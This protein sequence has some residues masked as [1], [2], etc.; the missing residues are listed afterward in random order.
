MARYSSM[1]SDAAASAARVAPPIAMSPCPGSARNRSISS[2]TPPEAR[3]AWPCTA[4]SVVEN[5]TFGSGFQAR[6]TRASSRRAMDPGR[7][8][9]ST[10]S[11]R[12]AVVPAG[13]R[14]PPESR[15]S[16]SERPPRRAPSSRSRRPA[17]R[18]SRQVRRSSNTS[19][20]A[21]EVLLGNGFDCTTAGRRRLIA[22]RGT[23][24]G[25]VTSRD[26]FVERNSLT[27]HLA[28]QRRERPAR[29]NVVATG[30]TS[31]RA[32]ARTPGR[33]A[34]WLVGRWE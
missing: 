5:T 34:E 30:R 9:P 17:R 1:R 11:S 21:S 31:M 16:R 13:G 3:R 7:R 32:R 6:S 29:S 27:S 20:C 26:H 23:S 15:R 12:T 14:R 19:R 4:D 25:R 33:R 2:A 8:S 10:A 28:A 24:L 22:A 18:C